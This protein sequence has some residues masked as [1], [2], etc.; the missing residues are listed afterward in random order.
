M[1]TVLGVLVSALLVAGCGG[2]TSSSAPSTALPNS[3][4]SISPSAASSPGPT[5]APQIPSE[6]AVL[7]GTYSL[8]RDFGITID[9]PAGWETCCGGVI[10]KSDFAALLYQDITDAVVYKDACLWS[11]GG[12]SEPRGAQAIAAALAAQVPRDASAPKA[13][14]VGGLP[15]V[16]VRLKVPADQPVTPVG[17]DRTFDGCHEGEF[18]SFTTKQGGTRYHQSPTQID[19]FYLVDIGTRTYVFDVVSARISPRR[20]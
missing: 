19:D 13:V 18:R 8:D 5:A 10:A 16:R 17:E 15:G 20:T 3:P 11:S 9:V 12:Q 6:G 1:R 14:K 4:A 2:A 7:P